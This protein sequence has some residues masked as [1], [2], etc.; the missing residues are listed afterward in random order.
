MHKI[1]CALLLS[2]PLASMAM[3]QVSSIQAPS[4]LGQ[5]TLYHN[6]SGFNVIQDGISH[7]VRNYNVDK[8]LR[9]IKPK[10]LGALGNIGYVRINRLSDGEFKL[11][12]QGRMNGGGPYFAYLAYGI[13]KAFCWSAVGVTAGAATATVVTATGGTAIVAAGAGT[14]VG[15]VVTGLGTAGMALTT[16]APAAGLAA[17]TVAAAGTTNAALAV[18]TVG[19]GVGIT[20][21]VETVSLGFSALFAGPWC[22]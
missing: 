4:S 1:V 2:L 19:A 14:T 20:A 11:D 17:A 15:K 22:P 10:L 5:V 9:S 16:T 13:A 21:A 7:P 6:E 3:N 8:S 18:T 12:L